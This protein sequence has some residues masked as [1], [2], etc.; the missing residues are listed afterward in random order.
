M[1]NASYDLVQINKPPTMFSKKLVMFKKHSTFAVWDQSW[2]Y[3]EV[4]QHRGRKV[5]ELVG[6]VFEHG[7]EIIRLPPYHCLIELIWTQV[8]WEVTN[9][10]KT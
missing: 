4:K 8:K 3:R 6:I 2:T 1:Y 9:Q 10:H 5:Y 7:H